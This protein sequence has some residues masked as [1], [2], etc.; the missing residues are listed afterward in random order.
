[1]LSYVL[2]KYMFGWVI[3]HT[4]AASFS[5]LLL[6]LPCKGSPGLVTD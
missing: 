1:M 4:L 2:L 3:P 6:L 5:W